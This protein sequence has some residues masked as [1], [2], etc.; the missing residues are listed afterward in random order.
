MY[1]PWPSQSLKEVAAQCLK[2]RIQTSEPQPP[3]AFYWPEIEPF[4]NCFIFFSLMHQAENDEL[5]MS[6][7]VAMAEIHLS[8]CNY[9]S[10]LLQG[11]PFGLRTYTEFTAHFCYLYDHLHELR[12]RNAN[13]WVLQCTSGLNFSPVTHF[14]I[15]I[16]TSED[17]LYILQTFLCNLYLMFSALPHFFLTWI[18]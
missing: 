7:P 9:A 4:L 14:W 2:S 12:L 6:L 5:G 8:A 18:S 10:V 16:F 13:R 11:Q 3:D 15:S 1:Q 17:R